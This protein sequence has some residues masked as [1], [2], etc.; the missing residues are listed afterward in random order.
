[1]RFFSLILMFLILTMAIMP[2]SEEIYSD[3]KTSSGIAHKTSDQNEDSANCNAFCNCTRCASSVI[4][5]ESVTL[6]AISYISIDYIRHYISSSPDFSG[7]IW[8]PPQ[9]S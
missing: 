5:P 8:Q 4:L 2:C 7:S 1:M 9:L 6:V 3:S